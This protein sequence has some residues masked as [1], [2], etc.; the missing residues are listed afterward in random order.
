MRKG[1]DVVQ[2]SFLSEKSLDVEVE[3]EERSIK[4]TD[5]RDF[6]LAS[7]PQNK[8]WWVLSNGASVLFK[9]FFLKQVC[10]RLFNGL[11]SCEG[12]CKQAQVPNCFL[13]LGQVSKYERN[14]CLGKK[15]HFILKCHK[16]S[17]TCY[18]SSL[19]LVSECKG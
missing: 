15:K 14:T 18:Y 1:E 16:N 12:K 5:S 6:I 3:D 19:L 10:L 11:E 13:L 17:V 9:N 4:E 7:A 2:S 8:T